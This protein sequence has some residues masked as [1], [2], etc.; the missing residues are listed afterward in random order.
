M[1]SKISD[2]LNDALLFAKGDTSKAVLRRYRVPPQISDDHMLADE[3]GRW[4]K[5]DETANFIEALAQSVQ[6]V[7]DA[8]INDGEHVWP[9]RLM[10]RDTKLFDDMGGGGQ[11][12][13]T[14]AGRGYERR[15]YVR[16]DLAT[17]SAR[18]AE[19]SGEVDARFSDPDFGDQPDRRR[20]LSARVAEASGEVFAW[21]KRWKDGGEWKLGFHF[22]AGL[23]PLKYEQKP[24]YASPQ[25]DKALRAS[26]VPADGSLA[27]RIQDTSYICGQ[28]EKNQGV[29]SLTISVRSLLAALSPVPVEVAEAACMDCGL[30]YKDDRF[31]DLVVPHDVWN[32]IAPDDGLLCPNC[33][34][35]RVAKSGIECKAVFR[36]GPFFE[37]AK[38]AAQAD[39]EQRI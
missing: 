8:P 5:V 17:L 22:D 7:S 4:V 2:G 20:A 33:L 21:A 35:A 23:D 19:A 29:S 34:C 10:I 3:A 13:Y 6:E 38:A 27:K 30:A 31:P 37:A 26:A 1:S 32:Q 9:A 24:L 18:V 28:W 16:A 36:S 25:G 11:R 15:E 14:T 12:I 39:Y